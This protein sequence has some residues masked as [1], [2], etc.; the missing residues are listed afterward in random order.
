MYDLEGYERQI[1]EKT[2]FL[3]HLKDQ[4]DGYCKT[5][6]QKEKEVKRHKREKEDAKKEGGRKEKKLEGLEED[7]AL[8]KKQLALME[9][10]IRM[11]ENEVEER[12]SSLLVEMVGMKGTLEEKDG[13]IARLTSDL[14]EVKDYIEEE[15]KLVKE[16]DNEMDELKDELKKEK[17]LNKTN[18][19]KSIR[20]VARKQHQADLMKEK[21]RHEQEVRKLKQKIVT[22]EEK[23]KEEEIA[24]EELQQQK[25]TISKKSNEERENLTQQI[26]NLNEKLESQRKARLNEMK[27]TE[28]VEMKFWSEEEKYVDEIRAIELSRQKLKVENDSL[29]EDMELFDGMKEQ[30]D[31]KTREVEDLKIELEE[32]LNAKKEEK[33]LMKKLL[34]E[35]EEVIHMYQSE[36]QQLKSKLSHEPAINTQE[37]VSDSVEEMRRLIEL[38]YNIGKETKG[39][40]AKED[41]DM[42]A[43]EYMRIIEGG[44]KIGKR[45]KSSSTK[46]QTHN[47]WKYSWYSLFLILISVPVLSSQFPTHVVMTSAML[48]VV[49]LGFLIWKDMLKQKQRS[50]LGETSD[51]LSKAISDIYDENQNLRKTVEQLIVRVA[52]ESVEKNELARKVGKGAIGPGGAKAGDAAA[53]DK[54]LTKQLEEKNKT[55]EAL[56]DIRK[57]LTEGGKQLRAKQRAQESALEQ[58]K[59]VIQKLEQKLRDVVEDEGGVDF[60]TEKILQEIR[61]DDDRKEVKKK[62]ALERFQK[63][64]MDVVENS[65]HEKIICIGIGVAFVLGV[66]FLLL[67]KHVVLF[68]SSLFGI[69]AMVMAVV[70][71][72]VVKSNNEVAKLA[73]ELNEEVERSLESS[74]EIQELS[75]LVEKHV[76]VSYVKV[77][78]FIQTFV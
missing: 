12:E 10:E 65:R 54:R 25:S 52:S 41:E 2:N 18:D 67:C 51:T 53:A 72:L 40:D 27:T 68:N 9:K 17:D 33:E 1:T 69:L 29:K 39:F 7:I 50:K 42:N 21:R 78:E 76:E 32:L 6:E 30:L 5:I 23:L 48:Y 28:D 38:E 71:G 59:K 58:N 22:M 47:V 14:M 4:V 26:K 64:A 37:G 36:V 13:K 60:S 70:L 20:E 66:V 44:S 16:K 49:T 46:H 75:T 15:A 45:Q 19:P 43:Q 56:Q 77:N 55:I 35:G 63:I 34:S 24:R 74:K 57:E 11:R 62:E 31:E 61:E 73:Q 3:Q 8:Q